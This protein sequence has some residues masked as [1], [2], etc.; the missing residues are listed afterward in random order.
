MRLHSEARAQAYFPST[1]VDGLDS[2]PMGT[3]KAMETPYV[4]RTH[5][6]CQASMEKACWEFSHLR[7]RSGM[8]V[9]NERVVHLN[10]EP[11]V[12]HGAGCG[13]GYGPFDSAVATIT[14]ASG[15]TSSSPITL[16]GFLGTF[17][18]TLYASPRGDSTVVVSTAPT[19]FSTGMFS[20]FPLYFPLRE[21]L[22]VA[23]GGS[24]LVSMWRK[25][26]TNVDESSGR[27]WYEWC[28]KVVNKKG[29]VLSMTPIH[30]PN[31][32]SYHVDL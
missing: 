21:P 28:A 27:V 29:E 9:G 25:I 2:A 14:Q 13:S 6:A 20:W 1:A 17:S 10:F 26:E 4:V 22:R 8:L 18:A 11:D 12:T 15:A 7:G 16:H 30:N 5:A 23:S 31:G 32:R 24:L 19:T 3:L